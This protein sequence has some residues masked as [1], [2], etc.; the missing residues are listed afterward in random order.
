MHTVSASDSVDRSPTPAERTA[1]AEAAPATSPAK[2][3]KM[4]IPTNISKIARLR[5][6]GLWKMRKRE[7]GGGEGEW[8]E[9]MGGGGT[10]IRYMRILLYNRGVYDI[11]TLAT[12]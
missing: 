2:R 4:T 6:A 10:Q 9:R 12:I 8:R 1:S 3:A 11:V 7:A 5:P